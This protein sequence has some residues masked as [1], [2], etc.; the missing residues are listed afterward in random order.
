MDKVEDRIKADNGVDN[1]LDLYERTIVHST[2]T[3]TLTV[4]KDISKVPS[5]LKIML[6]ASKITVPEFPKRE[7]KEKEVI[8]IKPLKCSLPIVIGVG[9]GTLVLSKIFL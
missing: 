6:T 3:G 2:A 8:D 4:H 7:E 5:N 9:L 1:V